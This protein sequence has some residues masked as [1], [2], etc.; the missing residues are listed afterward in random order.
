MK[1]LIL[2][3]INVTVLLVAVVHAIIGYFAI[4]SDAT[5]SFPPETAFLF[6]IPYA[7]AAVAL[8]A[9]WGIVCLIQRKRRNR[10]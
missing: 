4:M 9:V 3:M 5:T 7:V 1:K 8:N 10:L 6:L 2:I